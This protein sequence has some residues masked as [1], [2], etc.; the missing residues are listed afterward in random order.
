MPFKKRLGVVPQDLTLYEDLLR[1]VMLSFSRNYTAL[2][3][4][5]SK[6][7]CGMRLSLRGL[8]IRLRKRSKHFQAA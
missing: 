7:R 5:N 4:R 8:P 1:S 2:R 6:S 3:A